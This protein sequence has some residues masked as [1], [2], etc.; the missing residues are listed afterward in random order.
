MLLCLPCTIALEKWYQSVLKHTAVCCVPVHSPSYPRRMLATLDQLVCSNATAWESLH[1]E[2]TRVVGSA[3]AA[4]PDSCSRNSNSSLPSSSNSGGI[5]KSSINSSSM[6][7]EVKKVLRTQL[8]LRMQE[9]YKC[10]RDEVLVDLDRHFSNLRNRVYEANRDKMR[11]ARPSNNI[12]IPAARM[13]WSM[14]KRALADSKAPEYREGLARI[15][16]VQQQL[17]CLLQPGKVGG[18]CLAWEAGRGT[19]PAQG[20]LHK[21]MVHFVTC[22]CRQS[23]FKG[24]SSTLDGSVHHDPITN[25]PRTNNPGCSSVPCHAALVVILH[26]I[27]CM[28]SATAC[29]NSAPSIHPAANRALDAGMYELE[30]PAAAAAAAR[31]ADGGGGP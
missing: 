4:A 18:H 16:V 25:Q 7:A 9:Y 5:P 10:L 13:F 12:V 3:A 30:P 15:K 22:L 14:L 20:G 19:W 28:Q 23:L 29:C 17:N 21:H 11:K 2:L 24:V 31:T 27:S 8:T 1:K 26:V 6:A